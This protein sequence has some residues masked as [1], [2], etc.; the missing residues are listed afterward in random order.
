MNKNE[1]KTKILNFTQ[2]A[3]GL[4]DVSMMEIEK[5]IRSIT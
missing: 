1:K 5:N 2:F 4:S 3:W